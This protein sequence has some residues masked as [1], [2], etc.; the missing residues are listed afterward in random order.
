MSLILKNFDQQRIVSQEEIISI[1]EKLP[2]HHLK[3]LKYIVYDPTRFFKRSY[4]MPEITNY[5]IKGQYIPEL[6]DAIIIYEIAGKESFKHILLHEIGHFVFQKI[7]KPKDRNFWLTQLYS[8]KNFI[9][10]YART[11]VQEDFAESYSFYFQEK[12]FSYS[13]QEKFTFL[14]KISASI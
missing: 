4:V 2:K 8:K 12:F 14:K 13:L 9:S 10:D 7:L 3:G 5:Q 6:L 1:I 11:N